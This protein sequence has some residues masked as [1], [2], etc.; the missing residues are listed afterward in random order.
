[1]FLVSDHQT[2]KY[3]THRTPFHVFVSYFALCGQL[4]TVPQL[5][6]EQKPYSTEGKTNT[7]DKI[8]KHYIKENWDH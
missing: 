5:K 6:N 2:E 1:M 4:G 8:L 3:I 7:K